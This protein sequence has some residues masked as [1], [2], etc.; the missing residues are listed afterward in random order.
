M[1]Q[2]Q[3]MVMAGL[4]CP[5]SIFLAPSA[6]LTDF[7]N[8]GLIRNARMSR[9]KKNGKARNFFRPIRLAYLGILEKIGT[10]G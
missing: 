4:F 2:T 3:S 7:A 5:A 9:T 6:R 10:L 8:S 1:N